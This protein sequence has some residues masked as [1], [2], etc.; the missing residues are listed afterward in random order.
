MT[1]PITTKGEQNIMAGLKTILVVDDS[2][3]YTD[4][5]AYAFEDEAIVHRFYIPKISELVCCFS[6]LPEIDVAVIDL[7]ING[8][9]GIDIID[10]VRA[11]YPSCH[12]IVSTGCDPNHK[13]YVKAK[14]YNTDGIVQH[15]HHKNSPDPNGPTIIDRVNQLIQ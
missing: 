1:V 11:R 4:S 2:K 14:Q 15:I 8:I 9:T 6:T 7:L 12:I 5:L 10:L 3:I 13:V